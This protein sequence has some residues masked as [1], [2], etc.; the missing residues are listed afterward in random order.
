[1]ISAT[2]TILLAF[3][4]DLVLWIGPTIQEVT[5]PRSRDQGLGLK[6]HFTTSKA[7]NKETILGR[8]GRAST[9]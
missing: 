7:T 8:E 2:Q 9:Q 3:V 4:S 1:M 6:I 5:Y